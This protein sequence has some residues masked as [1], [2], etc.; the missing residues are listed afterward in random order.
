MRCP[1]LYLLNQDKLDLQKWCWRIRYRLMGGVCP[2][3]CVEAMIGTVCHC[4]AVCATL[5]SLLHDKDGFVGGW[6]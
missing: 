5:G 1:R 3:A 4:W 2:K 6:H